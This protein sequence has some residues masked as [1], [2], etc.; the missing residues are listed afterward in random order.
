MQVKA[1]FTRTVK[2]KYNVFYDVD[3]LYTVDVWEMETDFRLK[4]NVNLYVGE[5]QK[6]Q[7]VVNRR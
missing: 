4:R 1:L 7:F 5:N 3:H 2:N 6:F